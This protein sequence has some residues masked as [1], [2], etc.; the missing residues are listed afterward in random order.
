MTVV[1]VHRFPSIETARCLRSN[2]QHSL[3]AQRYT[4]SS[5][6][7]RSVH[8][9]SYQDPFSLFAMGAVAMFGRV[10]MGCADDGSA[11]SGDVGGNTPI[12]DQD[13]AAYDEG[14]WELQPG[15]VLIS[16]TR[17]RELLN[18]GAIL[19]DARA[20]EAYEREH[21]AG[22]VNTHWTRYVDGAQS[23]RISDDDALLVE[24]LQQNG[25]S[26]DVPVVVYGDW[27]TGGPTVTWG[28]E[29]RLLW[30]LEYLGHNDVHVV[31]GG[32]EAAKE[33]GLPVANGSQ[34]VVPPG[35]F[36]LARNET[37]R[38]T[39][40][41]IVESLQGDGPAVVLLDTR[42]PEEF[43]GVVKYGESRGGHIPGAQHLWWFDLFR[44]D[45]Q[46]RSPET[47]RATLN[48]LG[49]GEDAIVVPYC[50][51]GIRSGFVYLIL[52]SLG[53]SAQNYD[54]SMWEW[55]ADASLPLDVD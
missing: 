34:S 55:T 9:Y 52:R 48:R 45:G 53:Q 36:V 7:M 29:G 47:V 4:I 25:I 2:S 1:F 35:T 22:A 40:A 12:V 18:A 50:T 11:V 27:S 31:I 13:P 3:D 19:V 30:T 15:E 23:G 49:V 6:L 37:L 8:F 5:Y 33:L 39:S 16:A 21:L 51:G 44:D 43:A 46:L 54:G 26:S 32:L 41:E 28:E 20:A 38:A 10:L 17:A 14:V 42:E 24:L